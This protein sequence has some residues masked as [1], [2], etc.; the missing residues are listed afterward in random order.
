[1]SMSFFMTTVAAILAGFPFVTSCRYFSSRSGLSV[2]AVFNP[3]ERGAGARR[4]A[5]PDGHWLDW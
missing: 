1:M 5:K 3:R 2:S 4:R